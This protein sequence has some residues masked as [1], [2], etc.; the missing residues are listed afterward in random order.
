MDHPELGHTSFN[1]SGP[2][3][4]D[5]GYSEA[6]IEQLSN[7]KSVLGIERL[8]FDAVIGQVEPAIGENA[9]NI[10]CDEAN[11]GTFC[12]LLTHMMPARKRS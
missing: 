4:A 7:A 8:G 10:K 9:I 5:D 1:G 6:C 12:V 3:T 11:S 2:A